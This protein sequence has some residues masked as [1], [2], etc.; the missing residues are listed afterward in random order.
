LKENPIQ[1][2]VWL[3]AS[4][5]GL[6]LFRINVGTGWTSN[7]TFQV[8]RPGQY[9]CDKGD[10]ILRQAWP[11]STGAPKGYP[12]LSGYTPV[13]ITEDMVGKTIAVYTSFEVKTKTGAVRPEQKTF[14]LNAK[15]AGAIAGILRSDEDVKFILDES[16]HTI[17]HQPNLSIK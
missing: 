2:R 1:K 13:I 17:A 14:Y 7:K 9:F 10:V 4:E 12:D 16:G 3:K 5:L 6:K 15:Q 8:P 11:F